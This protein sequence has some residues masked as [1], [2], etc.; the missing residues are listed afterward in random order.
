MK[1]AQQ[2]FDELKTKY[3][4]FGD[5]VLLQDAY[6]FND[7]SYK[8]SAA[9]L[10]E[11]KELQASEFVD[12]GG[13]PDASECGYLT[14]DIVDIDCDDE[15]DVCDWEKWDAFDYTGA[16]IESSCCIVAHNNKVEK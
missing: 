2:I 5:Y 8:A 6:C 16:C 15:A 4:T 9:T 11:I 13:V 10:Q 3:G 1:N 12:E 14:W 7:T